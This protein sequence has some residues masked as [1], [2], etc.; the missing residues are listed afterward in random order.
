MADAPWRVPA[1]MATRM[2]PAW[3]MD[4]YA[5]R[6]L[7]FRCWSP[8]AL[9]ITIVAIA[10]PTTARCQTPYSPWNASTHTRRNAAKAAALTVAAMYAVIGFGEPSYT[11]GAHMWK[12]T[13]DTLN[14]K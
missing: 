11:S 1:A 8:T 5:S 12:G 6:R 14:P 9:P 7:R 2:N 3:A 13:V 4:E 10:R